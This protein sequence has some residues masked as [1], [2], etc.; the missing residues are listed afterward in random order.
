MSNTVKSSFIT[1]QRIQ[2]IIILIVYTFFAT[3]FGFAYR[4]A[5]N[6]DGISIMR[7]AGYIAEGN[8]QQSVSGAWS[9]LLSW[10]ISIFLFLGFNELTAARMVIGLSGAGFVFGVWKLAVRFELSDKIRFLAVIIA[11]LLISDWTIRFICADVLIA[12]LLVL[13]LNI[14]TR[15][16][17]L[18]QRKAVFWAGIV[19]G[20]AYLAKNYAFPFFMVHF[21]AML[22]LNYFFNKHEKTVAKKNIFISCLVGIAAFFLVASIW[23]TALSVKYGEFTIT[24]KGSI[25]HSLMGPEADRLKNSPFHSGLHKPDNDYALHIQEDHSGLSY[26]RWSPFESKEYFMHQLSLIKMNLVYIFN[27]F[28][29]LSPFFV[30]AFVVGVLTIIPVA[31][32][33]SKPDKSKKYLYSWI[34]MTFAIYCPGYI[35]LIAR[36]PRRF[37]MLMIIFVFL[38]FHCVEIL[39]NS[40]QDRISEK[41]KRIFVSYLL[42]IVVAAFA[43]KPGIHLMRSTMNLMTVDYVNSYKEMASQIITSDFSSPYAFIRSAQK[44]HTDYYIA[45]YLKEQFLGRPLSGDIKGLT[46]EL[47]KVNAR[48]LIVFDNL[49][50]VESLKKDDRF[51]H[52]STINLKEDSRYLNPLNTEID[53]ISAWDR[54]VNVFLVSYP[55]G[56]T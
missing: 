50:L 34:I 53:Q 5:I 26:S 10:L 51:I 46:N 41:R 4:Y 37:Y 14:V 54:N 16:D 29:N 19:G 31:F 42:L 40:V 1:Q 18:L 38:S 8:F 45:F 52:E 55:D 32:L 12:A 48:S 15:P 27:H 20:I 25:S 35:L 44:N 23:I 13:Y 33:L 24:K 2:L 43:V 47:L 21:P 9:P 30:Y 7:L 49:E 39:L 56:A 11:A 17:L 36:S 22:I 28:V 6:P 3:I